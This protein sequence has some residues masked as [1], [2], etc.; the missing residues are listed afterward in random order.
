MALSSSG[1][2]SLQSIE[3]EWGGSSPISISEY[4]SGSL[5]SDSLSNATTATIA[6][7]NSSVYTPATKLIG[8]YTT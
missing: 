7:H 8:A 4:Y 6:S 5:Q 2:I 3:G 1:S